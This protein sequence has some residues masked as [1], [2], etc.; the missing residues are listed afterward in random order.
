VA[1]VKEA[2]RQR[3]RDILPDD[4]LWVLLDTDHRT[5]G[6]HAPGFERALQD[7]ANA[8]I[9]VAISN[10]CF[11]IWLWAHVREFADAPLVCADLER[12]LK[13]LVPRFSKTNLDPTM[14][15][16]HMSVARE[17]ARTAD[18]GARWP[19]PRSTQVYRL[20]DEILGR[21]PE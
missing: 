19:A 9:R 12:E 20:L 3:Q 1:R 15:H 7:A 6:T 18:D 14:F 8:G 5:R 13:T 2:Q 16:P 11:E 17:R 4:Q 21:A 10:P